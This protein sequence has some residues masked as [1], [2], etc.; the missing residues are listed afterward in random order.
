MRVLDE[1]EGVMRARQPRLEL[2]QDGVDRAELRQLRAGLATA[3]DDALMHAGLFGGEEARQA[4]DTTVSG[5]T[6]D[7][8]AKSDTASRVNGCTAK[9]AST[10]CPSSVV[11]TAAT[12]DTLFSLP[13]PVLP[14]ERSPP[15]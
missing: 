7:L 12:N 8:A 5:R 2:A 13:R 10:A 4:I 15:R 11:W 6:S 3:G 1:I 9:Q 14:P